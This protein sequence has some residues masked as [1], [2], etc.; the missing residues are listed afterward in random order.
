MSSVLTPFNVRLLQLTDQAVRNLRPITTLDTFDGATKNFNTNGLFSNEIFGPAGDKQR[1][2]RFAYI[3]VKLPI[4][5]PLVHRTLGRLKRIYPEI[6]SGKVYARWDEQELDFVKSDPVDGRTGYAFFMEHWEKIKFPQRLSD[7]RELNIKFIERVRSMAT[8]TR[9]IVAPAGFRDYII[10]AD[11]REE[12]DEVN[13]LYRKLINASNAVT[14]EM[15]KMSPKIYDR[16]R[17]T[18]QATF[19]AIYEYYENIVKGK[20]KLLLG[21][22]MTR[23]VRDGT[24]NVI[25]TQNLEIKELF[26]EGTPT[27]NSTGIG[28][29]Q[30]MKAFRPKCLFH[31]Q[32]GFLRKIFTSP[33][34]PATLVNPK[35]LHA[36]LVQLPNEVYDLWMTREGHEKLLNLFGEEERRH[37]AVRV[38]DYYLALIYRDGSVFRLFSDIDDLPVGFDRKNVHP[39][40]FAEFMYS[41]VYVVEPTVT[42]NTTRFPVTGFGSI[43]PTEPFL[44]VTM[45]TEALQPLDEMWNKDENAMIAREFPIR[46]EAFMDT[47]MPPPDKLKGATA[48]FDGD[49]MTANGTY[50][51]EAVAES[52]AVMR[53][54]AFH[55]KTDGSIAHSLATDTVEFLFGAMTG[56]PVMPVA[57]EYI[58]DLTGRDMSVIRLGDAEYS[59]GVLYKN[60]NK[61]DQMPVQIPIDDVGYARS[62]MRVPQEVIDAAKPTQSILVERIELEGGKVR[63]SA[64]YGFDILIKARQEGFTEVSAYVITKADLAVAQI[65]PETTSAAEAVAGP[66]VVVPSAGLLAGPNM[67]PDGPE[68]TSGG[69]L[70]GVTTQGLKPH[71]PGGPVIQ[72]TTVNGTLVQTA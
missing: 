57:T 51:E 13:K 47:L 62:N 32:N 12:E 43:Y 72:A 27:T 29:F 17:Q 9:V 41:Q 8:T 39:I 26:G 4:I 54:R 64:I 16:A 65:V 23:Q 48:D 6:M 71:I 68:R 28:L 1:L 35:T 63:Y 15:F 20:N 42:M 52:K 49:K 7:L 10:M 67:A 18:M 45:R 36:E 40:T 55:V 14:M 2:R 53:S 24:R 34:A 59:P 25:T 44:K 46:G 61:H 5:H 19:N 56:K 60:V 33:G 66:T 3:D 50:T 30:F 37:A 22:V 69:P 70:V 58:D 11:Q 38:E 21:R 31:L